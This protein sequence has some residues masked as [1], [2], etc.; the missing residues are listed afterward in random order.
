MAFPGIPSAP[1]CIMENRE[2]QK[3]RAI[4]DFYQS[5][6]TATGADK[7][8]LPFLSFSLIVIKVVQFSAKFFL[9]EENE[10]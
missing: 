8:G 5:L 2:W 10:N 1:L 4:E 3:K 9:I 7:L 6:E